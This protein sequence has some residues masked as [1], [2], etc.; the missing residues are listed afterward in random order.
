MYKRQ[1]P[2]WERGIPDTAVLVI[3]A[4]TMPKPS[5]NSMYPVN[6]SGLDVSASNRAN[7]SPLA[8]IDTPA[9]SR[10]IRGP[11]LPTNRPASG[12]NRTVRPAIGSM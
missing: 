12:A 9:I 6:S 3:G 8:A 4:F 5:P 10:Q 2:A 1:T 7:S 11:R